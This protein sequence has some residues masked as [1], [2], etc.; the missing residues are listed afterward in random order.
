LSFW[1]AWKVT[2]RRAEI[3][4]SSPVL[5]LRPGRCGFSRHWKLPKPDSLTISPF[6]SARRTGQFDDIAFFERQ[7]DFIEKRLDDVLRL[8]FVQTHFFEQ[9]FGQI[10]FG[11]GGHTYMFIWDV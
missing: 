5:G 7:A 9:Q 8:A 6:S 10:S 1:L 4:I 11:K 2:T 3:G